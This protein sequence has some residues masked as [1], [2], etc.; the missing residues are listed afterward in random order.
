[1]HRVVAVGLV[2]PVSL[3]IVHYPVA[4][5]GEV[6]LALQI[7][8]GMRCCDAYAFRETWLCVVA[9]PLSRYHGTRVHRG[10]RSAGP[11]F[12]VRAEGHC[13]RTTLQPRA[14]T[15]RN[16][17]ARSRIKNISLAKVLGFSSWNLILNDPWMHTGSSAASYKSA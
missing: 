8:N 11:M 13:G 5:R 3:N 17:H 15:I 12:H 10:S 7:A 4:F 6:Y 14:T 2:E 1:M 9:E 16:A